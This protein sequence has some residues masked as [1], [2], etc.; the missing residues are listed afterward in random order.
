MSSLPNPLVM[1]NIQ[2]SGLVCSTGASMVP[3]WGEYHATDERDLVSLGLH[4]VE[5]WDYCG[6]RCPHAGAWDP[7]L[8]HIVPI[9]LEQSS[10]WSHTHSRPHWSELKHVYFVHFQVSN[11]VSA[12][13]RKEKL[14]QSTFT[15]TWQYFFK[16]LAQNNPQLHTERAD[17][18]GS[19]FLL[20]ALKS[21]CLCNHNWGRQ[22]V[23]NKEMDT[24]A[25]EA[26]GERKQA[27]GC[28]H[29][30]TTFQR[31]NKKTI[32]HNLQFKSWHLHT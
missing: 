13:A 14:K 5:N 28:K 30:T 7:P 18:Q 9:R 27:A 2:H 11:H 25:K 1:L 26:L 16:N 17:D 24:G 12:S 10:T 4:S 23:I 3:I 29:K 21:R 19:V 8:H 22:N 15:N 32:R 31:S 20:S 6:E